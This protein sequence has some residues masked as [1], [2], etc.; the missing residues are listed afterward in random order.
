MMFGG[1]AARLVSAVCSRARAA[2]M[3]VVAEASVNLPA[4]SWL[5]KML[6][7]AWRLAAPLPLT[8]PPL[9]PAAPATADSA[10]TKFCSGRPTTFARSTAMSPAAAGGALGGTAAHFEAG[11]AAGCCGN[12]DIGPT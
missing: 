5:Y 11:V 7:R 6:G 10:V 3:A 2:L 9:P 4:T 8:A 12:P 1:V